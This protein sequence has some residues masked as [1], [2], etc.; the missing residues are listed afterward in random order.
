MSSGHLEPG[1]LVLKG[2]DLLI[3]LFDPSPL[4]LGPEEQQASPTTP[5]AAVLIAKGVSPGVV[6]AGVLLGSTINIGGV[7]M[8]DGMV[9]DAVEAKALS[10]NPNHIDIYSASWGPDDDGNRLSSSSAA[11]RS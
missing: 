9:N 7:R 6:L 4:Q 10:L 8:L 5:V 11:A 3:G 2:A 1:T